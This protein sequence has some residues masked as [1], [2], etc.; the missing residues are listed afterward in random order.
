MYLH[1]FKC[2]ETYKPQKKKIHIFHSSIHNSEFDLITCWG[3][4]G[5]RKRGRKS[6]S[7]TLHNANQMLMYYLACEHFCFTSRRFSSAKVG[8]KNSHDPALTTSFIW[9][10]LAAEIL[11]R[12]LEAST[13]YTLLTKRKNLPILFAC[14]HKNNP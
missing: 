6:A 12:E 9:F 11:C 5:V 7:D 3:G 2:V 1:Y 13:I 10:L 4:G 8:D 14:I